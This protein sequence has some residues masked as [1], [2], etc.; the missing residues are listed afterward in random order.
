MTKAEFVAEVAVK[1]GLTR[2]QAEKAIG[3]FCGTVEKVVKNG[4][5]LTLLGF[6]TFS[7]VKR[8]ARTGRNPATGEDI[9]IPEKVVGK[10]APG[11]NLKDL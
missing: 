5:K 1:A 10:F 7:A 3:A 11:K 4:D 8:A 6:G 2:D 9:Q